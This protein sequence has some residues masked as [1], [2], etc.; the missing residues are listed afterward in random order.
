MPTEAPEA[1]QA[2][3]QVV[4]L[5][6]FFDELQRRVPA[7]GKLAF[8]GFGMKSGLVMWPRGILPF[9]SQDVRRDM[10]ALKSCCNGSPKLTV[11]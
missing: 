5:L 4:F 9:P 6:T 3:S 1:R 11:G 7:S 2:Q 8:Q 10:Y